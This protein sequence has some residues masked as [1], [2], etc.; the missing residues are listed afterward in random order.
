VVVVMIREIDQLG[1]VWHETAFTGCQT[2]WCEC[3][4]RYPW[5]RCCPPY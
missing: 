3:P 4:W 1:R 2:K 5:D